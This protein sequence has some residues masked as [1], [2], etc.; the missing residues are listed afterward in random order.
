MYDSLKVLR[1]GFGAS[2]TEVKVQ[3]WAM[4]IIYY[5]ENLK[6]EQNEMTEEG[7]TKLFQIL[8]NYHYYLRGVLWND[9]VLGFFCV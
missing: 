7:A 1:L 3:F 6:K 8:N 5:G 4:S 2:E 9:D